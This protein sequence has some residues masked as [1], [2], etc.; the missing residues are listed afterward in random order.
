MFVSLFQ[1][2]RQHIFDPFHECA[3]LARQ[4][5]PI[6]MDLGAKYTEHVAGTT[7]ARDV[8]DAAQNAAKA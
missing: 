5:A 6:W 7:S 8:F 3:D 2:R 1:I 4:I